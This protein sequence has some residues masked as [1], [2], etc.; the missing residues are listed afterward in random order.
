MLPI[1]AGASLL[2]IARVAIACALGRNTVATESEVWLQ[3]PGACFVTLVLA[4]ELRGCIGSLEARRP[5]LADVKANAVAA[6]LRDSRFAPLLAQEFDSTQ[7]EISVLSPMQALVFGGESEAL[8][9]LRPGIDGVTFE[10]SGR[11]STFLPQ[12]WEQLPDRATFIAH[13]KRKAGFATDFWSG[14]I[15]IRRYTVSKWIES[16]TRQDN[17]ELNFSR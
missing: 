4:G 3:Q 1:D 10:C 17:G 5:L 9:Q 16:S 11:R 8:A 12:V 13:L 2:P 6:A 14:D 7:I 15:R